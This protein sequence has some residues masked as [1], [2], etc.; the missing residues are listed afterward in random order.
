MRTDVFHE[1][2]KKWGSSMQLLMF[3]EESSE[4]NKE[5]IKY[6]RG[7]KNEHLILEEMAD[8]YIMLEQMKFV[9]N[10]EKKKLQDIIDK[11]I[12]RIERR[13]NEQ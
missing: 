12:N 13:L 8:V 9:F 10:F 1:T 4:L 2:I 6:F 5:I 7:D 11:K 3:I